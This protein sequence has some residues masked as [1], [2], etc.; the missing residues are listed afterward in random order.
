MPYDIYCTY[1]Q[2]SETGLAGVGVMLSETATYTVEVYAAP[3][4]SERM[5]RTYWEPI[6]HC[7][8]NTR[9]C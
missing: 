6:F 4:F 1:I 5:H 3:L 7:A 9:S 8:S 2:S